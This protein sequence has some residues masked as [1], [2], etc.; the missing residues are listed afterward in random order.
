MPN[1]GLAGPVSPLQKRFDRT[2]DGIFVGRNG[3]ELVSPNSA[4]ARATR[5]AGLIDNTYFSSIAV[6]Q[7]W[8]REDEVTPAQPR[9]S[10]SRVSLQ[11]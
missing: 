11:G 3:N 2:N 9:A 7:R 10:G 5:L 8:A 6:F 4:V 1:Q